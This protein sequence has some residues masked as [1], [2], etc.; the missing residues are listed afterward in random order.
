MAYDDAL[1]QHALEIGGPVLRFYGWTEKAATFGYF[2]HIAEIEAMTSLRPLVRRP[3]GGG[4]VPHD[5]DWTYS[6]VFARG[7]AWYDLKAE[8]SYRRIHE[9]VQTAF[10]Q[11]SVETDIAPCCRKAVAGQC[12]EG[13]E[14]F[15]LL[16]KGKKIAGA[17]QRR[18]KTALLIQ[19]SVQPPP[20]GLNREAWENAMVSSGEKMTGTRFSTFAPDTAFLNTVQK[21]AAEVYSTTVHNRRR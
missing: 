17:A 12:F 10:R 7:T 9:W 8:E 16:W 19:G 13:Y 2:Q 5:A 14:K 3:T 21:L 20:I 1:L 4:L 11:M 15:D 6:A 18:T